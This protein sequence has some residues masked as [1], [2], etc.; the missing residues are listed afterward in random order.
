ML[1]IHLELKVRAGNTFAKLSDG[2][3]Y[4]RRF[5]TRR[6]VQWS[7]NHLFFSYQSL[8]KWKIR[9]LADR[10]LPAKE[11][12]TLL[13]HVNTKQ[14]TYVSKAVKHGRYRVITSNLFQR[15]VSSWQRKKS[16]AIILWDLR[17]SRRSVLRL[18]TSGMWR[19]V[20]WEMLS[21][22]SEEHTAVIFNLWKQAA[23]GE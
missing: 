11:E 2:M 23:R 10:S 4:W 5:T 12:T 22:V 9:S 8:K 13:I 14:L 1:L 17:F 3:L 18:R 6:T 7:S 15:S 20:I 16:N 19:C 21:N